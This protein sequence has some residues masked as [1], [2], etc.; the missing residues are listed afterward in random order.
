MINKASHL[1]V[2]SLIKRNRFIRKFHTYKLALNVVIDKTIAIYLLVM[3]LYGLAGFF[4]ANDLIHDYYDHFQLWEAELQEN[5][6]T[7][8]TVLPIIYIIQAFKN[9][10]VTFSSSEYQLSLLPYA[11]EKIWLLTVFERWIKQFINL[12]VVGLLVVLVTPIS[13]A[14]IGEYMII[15]L[16]I[17]MLMTIPQWKLFQT[18]LFIKFSWLFIAVLINIANLLF[19]LPLFMILLIPLLISLNVIF[20]SKLFQK[21]KWDRVTEVCDF[22]IWT[23]WFISKV[24]K[25]EIKRQRKFSIFQN[26]PGRKNPFKYNEKSIYKRLWRNYLGKN[27][28]TIFQLIGALFIFIFVFSFVEGLIFHIVLAASIHMYTSI[29]RSFFVGRFHTDIVQVLPWDLIGYKRV[30]FKWAIIGSVILLV[31][32]S[33]F[34]IINLSI[35]LPLQ[36]L[37]FASTFLFLYHIRIEKAISM[38][39]KEFSSF[40][41][42]ET[43]GYVLLVGIVFSWKYKVILFIGLIIPLL[44]NKRKSWKLINF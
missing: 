23:M 40:D 1:N 11:R 34:L 22:K 12:V 20:K 18:N 21:V 27:F 25:V 7:I 17:N 8:F 14:L 32:L 10:G 38:L 5:F 36:L 33:V 41:L 31:P 9:P 13:P 30:F 43:I 2:Y 16:L 37:Y 3:G 35:W 26:L 29:L 6:R 24:S 28:Q 19:N 42:A 44:I 15:F 39:G 4:I